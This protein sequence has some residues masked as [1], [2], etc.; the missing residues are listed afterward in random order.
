M[1]VEGRK[2]ERKD[3]AVQEIIRI[4]NSVP[5][6]LIQYE[7]FIQQFNKERQ[8]ETIY[9]EDVNEGLKN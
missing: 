2:D 3:R 6:S 9:L 4:A 1:K 7:A 5:Y 8:S